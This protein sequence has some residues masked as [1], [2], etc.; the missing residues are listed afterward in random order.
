MTKPTETI[1]FT[2]YFAA[3]STQAA[4]PL[5]PE[6]MSVLVKRISSIPAQDKREEAVRTLLTTFQNA[7]E[8]MRTELV[9]DY[10][11]Q[12]KNARYLDERY[13]ELCAQ[14]RRHA[15]EQAPYEAGIAVL[16]VDKFKTIN[17]TLGHEAGDTVLREIAN[18][19]RSFARANEVVARIGGDEFCVLFF[20]N[21][22]G[23][24]DL[25]ETRARYKD[26]LASI[27]IQIGNN[28]LNVRMSFGAARIDPERPLSENKALADI[29]LYKDKKFGGRFHE[30]MVVTGMIRHEMPDNYSF[31]C[32]MNV[33]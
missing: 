21:S 24:F 33:E 8:G 19:L 4:L 11:T 12:L 20:P 14:S 13:I 7:L 27:P 2:Q 15:Y 9:I 1:D 18:Y 23:T 29:E 26:G 17:D 6:E 31:V 16:D 32:N 3:C 25:K 5:K 10:L 28:I 30:M 22:D